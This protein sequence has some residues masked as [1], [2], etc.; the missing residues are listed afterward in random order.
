MT[1][2][3]KYKTYL[4]YKPSKS[5]WLDKIPENWEERRLKFLISQSI[6]DGPHDTPEFILDGVPFLSVDGIQDDRLVFDGCRYISPENHAQYK[7][8]CFPR[9][10]DILLGKAAS[11]GKVAIVD[12]DFEFNVWSP[13]ALIRP[14]KSIL[15]KF[16]YYSLKSSYLQDQIFIL[17]TSNTQH[18]L[19][20]DDIPELWI[21]LPDILTQ[22][23][24]SDYLDKAT[25]DLDQAI[26]KIVGT[27]T[28]FD[29]NINI[30]K[31]FLG[32]VKEYKQ[33][34]IT[35]AVTGKIM[36]S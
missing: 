22:K 11:V 7:L 24:I 10:G 12:V 29:K 32:L 14:N 16:L 31:S 3:T 34:L 27:N 28:L 13:L 4:K 26:T 36:V 6:T 19:S 2:A 1:T 30:N 15:P 8:K 18:N 20:M 33:G 5:E 23:N 35:S 17:S 9:K 21:S 25:V